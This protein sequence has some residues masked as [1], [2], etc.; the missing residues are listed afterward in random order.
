[1]VEQYNEKLRARHGNSIKVKIISCH[2]D[3]DDNMYYAYTTKFGVSDTYETSEQAYEAANDY[4]NN[5]D[6]YI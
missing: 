5:I 6:L 1:M 3:D 2:D 4:L